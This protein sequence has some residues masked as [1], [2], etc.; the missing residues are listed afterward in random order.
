MA[1]FHQ[2]AGYDVVA[3]LGKG[4]ASTLY[5]VRDKS[6][7]VYCLKR[8][9]KNSP[10]EQR[11]LDQ[12]I[13]EYEVAKQFDS[14]LLRKV[15]K[16]IRQRALIRTNEVLVLMELVEGK[17]I[18]LIKVS[19]MP[20]FCRLFL[21]VANGLKLMHDAGYVHADIKPSN[22]MLDGE[23]RVKIIDLGQS[24][25]NG[26][27]KERIQGTPDYIAPEQVLRRQI[28]YKTDVFNLGATMYWM[29]TNS[30]VPTLIPK[31][32]NGVAIRDENYDEVPSPAEHDPTVPPALS[33][34][35]MEC[36]QTEPRQRPE[37]IQA[38]IDRV[39][40]AMSQAERAGN[41]AELQADERR[42]AG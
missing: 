35:V 41:A 30:H 39:S 12:A 23:G 38:V 26:T 34:L 31:K 10:G 37:S 17:T 8:V 6:G 42:N 7:Q 16:L 21:A 9:V 13:G 22:I 19:G 3:T 11:Y 29:L 18:D 36:V 27:I 5:S 14:P 2:I 33:N 15:H 1:E 4:A 32:E 28:T 40:I 24:C 20:A 25:K